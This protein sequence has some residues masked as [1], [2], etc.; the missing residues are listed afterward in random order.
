LI[1]ISIIAIRAPDIHSKTVY[2]SI[3]QPG[4]VL[5]TSPYNTVTVETS[6]PITDYRF[7]IDNRDDSDVLSLRLWSNSTAKR[8]FDIAVSGPTLLLALP[9]FAAI[10]ALIKLTSRG[11]VFFRQ[12]RMGKGKVPFIIYKFRTM[13]VRALHGP[14]VTS[15]DDSRITVVGKFLRRF[16]LD[17][18]PQIFNVLRGDMSFVGPRPKV[19]GHEQT[20]LP[21][22]P[23][24]TGA[25]TLVFAQ[26]ENLLAHIPEHKVEIF[27]VEVLHPI[28]ASL[29]TQYARTSTFM[30]DFRLLIR[31]ILHV[32]RFKTIDC[33]EELKTYS[34]CVDDYL[35][36]P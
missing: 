5:S 2:L 10:A 20:E 25:A 7:D 14:L 29:D 6:A 24:I 16:K 22:K 11:P 28:K 26:E 23:G 4:E 18:L 9:L 34:T 33:I 21:C 19:L 13:Q 17:E 36:S 32:T 31:T 30:T 27:T 35:Y 15:K 12:L 1:L 8:T 3:K